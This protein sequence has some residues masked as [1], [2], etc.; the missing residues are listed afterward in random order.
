MVPSSFGCGSAV[1]AA[2]A[3]LAPSRAARNAMASPMPRLPPDM[4]SV[5]P[6]RD[7]IERTPNC[8]NSRGS[9]VLHLSLRERSEH[10]DRRFC[11][12]RAQAPRRVRGYTLT[13]DRN[14]SPRPSPK[15]RGSPLPLPHLIMP[16]GLRI[17][18]QNSAARF[19]Q[20][21]RREEEHA[22]SRHRKNRDGAAERCRGRERTDQERKQR[23]DAAAE[24]VAEA[25]ARSA[26]PCRIEFGEEG[27]HA[28]E[29]S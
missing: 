29:I 11:A 10:P 28:G 12:V 27:P 22:V 17:R 24:I 15:G 19:R 18:M 23:A 2:I 5:L 14:P 13:I 3:M 6:L 25:L 8:F 26:Q 7:V 20:R 4:N 9:R 16:S 21:K 1:F